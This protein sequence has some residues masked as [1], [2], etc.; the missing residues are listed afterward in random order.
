MSKKPDHVAPAPFAQH[1]HP[2]CAASSP[3]AGNPIVRDDIAV[4]ADL[5]RQLAEVT[6]DRDALLLAM[7]Y[8]TA[9]LDMPDG[10]ELAKLLSRIGALT[11][12]AAAAGG[13]R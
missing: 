1:R 2:R 5:R 6:A 8:I 10:T 4:I 12:A 13:D 7:E 3:A 9:A 11:E